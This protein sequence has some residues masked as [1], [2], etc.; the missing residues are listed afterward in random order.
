MNK[1]ISLVLVGLLA[2][3]LSVNATASMSQFSG[4]WTNVDSNTGGLTTLDISVSG[5]SAQV[6]A[7]GKCHPTDCDW[8]SVN[9]YAFG[10]DVGS[11]LV[12]NAQALL[13]VFNSGHSQTTLVIQPTSGNR[14]KVMSFDR[15]TDNS[16]RS[17][18]MSEDTFQKSLI[19]TIIPGAIFG[20][21]IL[22]LSAP[23]Q[24]SPTSGSVFDNYPRTTTLRW[25]PV[26]GAASYT[27]EIDCYHC[28]QSGK[29]CTDVGKT[30]KVVPGLTGT[31]YTFD[32]VGAQ[33]G[34]WRVWAVDSSGVEGF[35]SVWWNFRYTR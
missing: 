34:R 22:R 8:G 21:A 35:K 24:T 3:F 12:N 14:L 20:T 11:N 25:S 4:R 10:P 6:H 16:G 31:S 1:I 19:G 27:V 29:W 5:T 9:A 2:L 18:Y 17:N 7:W 13:A 33:A 15:F 23:V 30:W 28:C 26:S 32:Y